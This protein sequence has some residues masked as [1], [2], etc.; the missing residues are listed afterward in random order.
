[1][2]SYPEFV[3]VGITK[4]LI[5]FAPTTKVMLVSGGPTTAVG[6]VLGNQP[7]ND[8]RAEPSIRNR[9]P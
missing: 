7:G 9:S 2:P 6:H 5:M 3:S 8:D 1:M 4:A